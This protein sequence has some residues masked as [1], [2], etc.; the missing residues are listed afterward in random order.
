MDAVVTFGE[1]VAAEAASDRKAMTRQLEGAVRAMM[2]A[3]LNGFPLRA[4]GP[5]ASLKTL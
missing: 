4:P 3:A 2:A 1:P 5:A